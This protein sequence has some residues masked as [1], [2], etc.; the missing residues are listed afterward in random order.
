MFKRKGKKRN[1]FGAVKTGIYKSKLEAKCGDFLTEAGIE[2]EYE[3]KK[4]VLQDKFKYFNSWERSGKRFYNKIGVAAITYT[5]DFVGDGWIIETK[6]H[7][8]STF[9][10]KWKM[11]KKWMIENEPTVDIYLPTN[12]KEL[13]I[14][15]DLI[16][17]KSKT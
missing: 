12:Q 15:I 6:G 7:K 13:K 16:N 2:F 3:S 5:P 14:V 4:I 10:L 11:F 8:T 17:S 9:N 1:N